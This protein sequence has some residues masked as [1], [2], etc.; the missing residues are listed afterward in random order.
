MQ[1]KKLMCQLR[2]AEIL[3]KMMIYAPIA[4][5]CAIVIPA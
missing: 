1:L 2:S 5:F 3:F 4:R